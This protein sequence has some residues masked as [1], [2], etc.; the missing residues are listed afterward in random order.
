[1]GNSLDLIYDLTHV[2]KTNL[3]QVRVLIE[4][5]KLRERY[6]GL[7]DVLARFLIISFL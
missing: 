4:V 6:E 3:F 2:F 5:R 7:E 1:M